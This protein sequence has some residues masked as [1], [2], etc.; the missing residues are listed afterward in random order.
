MA[1]TTFVNGTVVQPSW[2]NDVNNTTYKQMVSVRL[3]GAIGN[4]I[5]DDTA[6]IQATINA[7]FAAGGGTVYIPAGTYMVSALSLNWG[8]APTSI[9]FAGD[10]Q[11]ATVLRK[12]SGTSTP[13][14]T[15]TAT[16]GDGIYSEIRD[17]SIFADNI[18]SRCID[19]VQIARTVFRSVRCEGATSIGISAA[20]SL[21]NSFYDCNILGCVTGYQAR[22]NGIIRS[23]LVQFFGGSIR[24][25]TLWGLDIGDTSVL[26]LHGLDI[27]TNGTTG[28]PNTGGMI[29]RST[30]GNEYAGANMSIN[31][32]WFEGNQGTT[33]LS[34]AASNLIL[35]IRDTPFISADGNRSM[36]IGAISAIILDGV[37]A[38][39]AA[40]GGDTVT[41]AAGS[42]TIRGCAIRVLT[43]T[44]TNRVLEN[45]T[46]FPPRAPIQS[47]S[48]LG[49][50]KID[51]PS[52]NSGSG[53]TSTTTG[54]AT[55]IATVSGATPAM[56]LVF[57]CLGGAGSTYMSNARIGW[58]ATNLFRMGGENGANL[59]IT[60]S[61]SN[62][63]VTQ[64]SGLTQL[65]AWSI[66]RIS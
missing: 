28:N 15:L 3:Y 8:T 6:A 46:N 66:L 26:N 36:T 10:G 40:G 22:L 38:N 41:L 24:S 4:G 27:E 19:M 58:D 16:I 35:T 52:I 65:V 34:E 60:T 14:L 45:V 54:V 23:N 20:G 13:V 2:L 42:S 33:L 30:C 48:S 31:G 56:F 55:T 63:Q 44:S 47:E 29:I 17:L 64:I 12:I 32:S 18:A 43:D 25:N 7:V 1:D 59:T 11:R 21:I 61:G 57:A 53:N 37:W 39:G 9:V 50:L 49:T 51:G 5:A 62:I